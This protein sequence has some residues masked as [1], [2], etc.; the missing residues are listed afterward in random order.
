MKVLLA[1]AGCKFCTLL[2]ED[3][4]PLEVHCSILSTR[5]QHSTTVTSA[6]A[7]KCQH[8]SQKSEVT[9][10]CKVSYLPHKPRDSPCAPAKPPDRCHPLFKVRWASPGHT[11]DT[12]SNPFPN[13]SLSMQNSGSQPAGHN[14]YISDNY[15]MIHNRSNEIISCLG[16]HTT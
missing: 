12:A 4:E 11:G 6:L 15:I 8:A 13:F 7:K 10:L 2:P 9:S 14:P 3:L 16:D 5:W 1:C